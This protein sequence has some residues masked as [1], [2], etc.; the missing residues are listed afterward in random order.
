MHFLPADTSFQFIYIA[1]VGHM[2]HLKA[3]KTD[4]QK[5][6]LWNLL[7]FCSL[8][9][10]TDVECDTTVHHKNKAEP[11]TCT[12]MHVNLISSSKRLTKILKSFEKLQTSKIL[13]WILQKKI[14][15]FLLEKNFIWR[16]SETDWW[17]SLQLHLWGIDRNDKVVCHIL[18][19]NKFQNVDGHIAVLIL[20]VSH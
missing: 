19:W 16:E 18:I 5:A 1:P 11:C 13:A 9:P 6:E 8:A 17:G 2:C 3:L 4:K 15:T 20:W 12:T 10:A 7:V 14:K